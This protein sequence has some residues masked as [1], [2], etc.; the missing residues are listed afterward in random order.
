MVIG[1]AP[2]L[3]GRHSFPGTPGVGFGS[4]LRGRCSMPGSLLAGAD[5][6]AGEGAQ[7]RFDGRSGGLRRRRAVPG[8]APL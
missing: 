1:V 4:G 3:P 6:T 7:A 8:Q 5:R 2:R